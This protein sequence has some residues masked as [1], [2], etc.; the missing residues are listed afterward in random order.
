MNYAI[1]PKAGAGENT[2]QTGKSEKTPHLLKKKAAQPGGARQI[3][4]INAS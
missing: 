1:L 4:F 3:L 2:A